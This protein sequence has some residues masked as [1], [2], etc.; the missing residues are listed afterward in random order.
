MASPHAIL[1][2]RATFNF[3]KRKPGVTRSES[4]FGSKDKEAPPGMP[5]GAVGRY[6][7]LM[8]R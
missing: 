5:G 2:H 8:A 6:A 3:G 4:E 7:G 1:T